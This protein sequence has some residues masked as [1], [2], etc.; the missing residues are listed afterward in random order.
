MSINDVIYNC[1]HKQG[2]IR[3]DQSEFLQDWSQM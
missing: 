3:K 2:A 1:D